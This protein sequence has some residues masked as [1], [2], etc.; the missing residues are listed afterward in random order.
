LGLVL[1]TVQNLTLVGPRISEISRSDK[2][3]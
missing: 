3:R 1:T 2:K